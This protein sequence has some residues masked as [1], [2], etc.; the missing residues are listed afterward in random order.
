LRKWRTGLERGASSDLRPH[1]FGF[2]LLPTLWDEPS[3][4]RIL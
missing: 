3:I 1:H 4:V 2:L